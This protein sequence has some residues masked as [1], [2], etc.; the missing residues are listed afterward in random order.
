[1]LLAPIPYDE[2]YTTYSNHTE[3][4]RSDLLSVAHPASILAIQL[5]GLLLLFHLLAKLIMHLRR[6][7][8][9]DIRV[10]DH[11][12]LLKRPAGS[13]GVHEENMESHH[14]TEDSKD[15]IRL[16][17]DVVECRC[18]EV[19]E[20]EIENPVS[21]RGKS[22]ALGS[23]FQREDFGGVDPAGRCLLFSKSG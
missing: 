5:I 21:G 18:D 22:D 12:N 23:V 15:D 10:E 19:R 9:L 2:F 17:L 11:I 13:F 3:L 16:P 7:P 8:R 6:L 20:C 14:E 4:M 1:M